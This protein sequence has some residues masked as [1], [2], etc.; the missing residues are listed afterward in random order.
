MTTF[1]RSGIVAASIAAIFA[2][3]TQVQAAPAKPA[4]QIDIAIPDI[5]Y[6]KFVLK[7]GLTSSVTTWLRITTPGSSRTMRPCWWWATPR[8]PS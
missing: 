2:A 5:A 8:W 6:T 3:G 4:G 7:N 1:I